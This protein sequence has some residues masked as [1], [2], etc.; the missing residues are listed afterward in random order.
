[1]E[2][3][4]EERESR[5]DEIRSLTARSEELDEMKR[6]WQQEDIE[7]SK[8]RAEDEKY[9]REVQWA[10]QDTRK[11]ATR[12]EREKY[13]EERRIRDETL[14]VHQHV[15][16]HEWDFQ[17]KQEP[18]DVQQWA[19]VQEMRKHEHDRKLVKAALNVEVHA[20]DPYAE[21]V[22]R[23]TSRRKKNWDSYNKRL[24]EDENEMEKMKKWYTEKSFDRAD[25]KREAVRETHLSRPKKY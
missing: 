18:V 20:E 1:M 17:Q 24:H 4:R 10:R 7:R 14:L 15:R 23:E 9:R 25:A 3:R 19:K 12:R 22:F 6:K 2:K 8:A 21:T 16:D 11:D 13:R 5:R